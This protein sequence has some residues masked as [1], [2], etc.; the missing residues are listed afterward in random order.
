MLNISNLALATAECMFCIMRQLSTADT[1]THT[2]TLTLTCSCGFG[3]T[4][5]RPLHDSFSWRWRL[6]CPCVLCAG[7]R[8]LAATLL[9]STACQPAKGGRGK[10]GWREVGVIV[11]R[12]LQLPAFDYNAPH[13]GVLGVYVC[14]CVCECVC[15]VSWVSSV[16]SVSSASA[17][18][19]LRARRHRLHW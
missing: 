3:H 8:V 19:A 2:Q 10:E 11:A 17:G 12:V 18:F 9:E 6:L 5:R 13:V 4:L 7:N 1:H 15:S 14:V 16:Y